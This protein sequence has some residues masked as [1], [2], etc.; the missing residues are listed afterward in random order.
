MDGYSIGY[1]ADVIAALQAALD[2]HGNV[3]LY[4]TRLS[5]DEHMVDVDPDWD[6]ENAPDAVFLDELL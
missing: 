5:Q 3:L 6:G 2:E 1:L 4:D